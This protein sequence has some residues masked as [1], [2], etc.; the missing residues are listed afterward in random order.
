VADLVGPAMPRTLAYHIPQMSAV[1]MSVPLMVDLAGRWPEVFVGIKDSG[2]DLTKMAALRNAVPD[3][4]VFAGA[5]PLMRP[6]LAMGGAGCITATA[7]L[8]TRELA[9]IYALRPA[10]D[11]ASDAPQARVEAVRALTNLGPQ[12]PTVKAMIAQ[13]TGHAGWARVRAPLMPADE[14]VVAQLLRRFTP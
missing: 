7:N 12:I 4:A 9:A 13:R 10:P 14:A 2:G 8:V 5:D 1:P 11:G 6:L 3:L